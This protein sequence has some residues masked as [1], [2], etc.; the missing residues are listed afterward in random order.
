MFHELHQ[1]GARRAFFEL[2]KR[3][4]KKHKTDI[5]VSSDTLTNQEKKN[6]NSSYVFNFTPKKWK[7]GDW[8]T[9]LFKDTIEYVNIL[10]HHKKIADKINKKKYDLVFVHPSRFTQAPFILL[11][12]KAPRIY[13]CQEPLRIVYDKAL[14]DLSYLHG[15]KKAYEIFARTIRRIIDRVNLSRSNSIFCNSKYSYLSIRNAYGVKAKVRYLGVDH[16]YFTP[17]KSKKTIDVLYFGSNERIEMLELFK[18]AILKLPKKVKIHEHFP[19]SVWMDDDKLRDLYRKSKIVVTLH[20]NEPFGLIP[21]EAA[22]CGVPV[23]A[24]N[25]GGHKESVVHGKTGFLISENAAELA[26]SIQSLLRND[27]KRVQ[28]GLYARRNVLQNWTWE[29]SA[30]KIM[31]DFEKFYEKRN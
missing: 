13:Y 29:K 22:A 26:K 7:K 27:K 3:I 17:S 30:K 2:G 8:I 31:E 1:G 15:F 19:G 25:S 24:V 23:I 4:S 12:L 6:F 11:F 20:K 14:N 9:K 5:Y 16:I 28:M 21:I 10:N 18:E